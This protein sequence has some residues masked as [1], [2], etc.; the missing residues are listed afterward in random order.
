MFLNGMKPSTCRYFSVVH[1]T[2][3][4]VFQVI[5]PLATR[6][7]YYTLPM[8]V[9]ENSITALNEQ[10]QGFVGVSCDMIRVIQLFS[11]AGTCR[12]SDLSSIS[13]R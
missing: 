6:I 4:Y 9:M 2:F 10:N 5:V 12:S 8:D 1:V 13:T 7:G 3:F 11:F